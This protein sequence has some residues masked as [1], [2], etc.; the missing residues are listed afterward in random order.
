VGG[1]KTEMTRVLVTGGGGFLGKAIVKRLVARKDS[2]T[3]FSRGFYPQLEHLGVSQIQGDLKDPEAVDAACRDRQIV[4]HV[5][6]KAGIWGPEAAYVDA[7]VTGT[8]NVVEACLRHQVDRLV[9]TSSPSVVFDGHDMQGVDASV[10]YANHFP[11]AYPRTK[12]VAEQLVRDAAGRGLS[13][14]VLRPH[15]IWGPGDNHLVPRILA[16]AR[17]LVQVGDGCNLVDTIY[18]DNAADAHLAAAD[19]LARRPELSGRVYFISQGQP[20]PLWEMVNAI[21][22]A[23]GKPPVRRRMSLSTARRI[24]AVLEFLYR[25]FNI[26]SEPPMTRFMA[27]ELATSHWFDIRAARKDLGYSPGVSTEEGLRRLASWLADSENEGSGASKRDPTRG[28]Y[29]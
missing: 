25:L 17:G 11:A 14:I 6:A 20:M 10:P 24:G 29:S 7:N 23:G 9:Y 16:K 8:R 3:S 22:A 15:L 18:I 21:L 2:V 28:T 12:A 27:E 26:S 13:S 5:A 1:K 19:A 4:F